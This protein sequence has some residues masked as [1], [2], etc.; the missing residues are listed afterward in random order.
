MWVWHVENKVAVSNKKRDNIALYR[1]FSE[2]DK[3]ISEC[4]G[5]TFNGYVYTYI[6]SKAKKLWQDVKKDISK[7]LNI[8]QK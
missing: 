8:N 6:P 1:S 2:D 7:A 5:K 4:L 3:M